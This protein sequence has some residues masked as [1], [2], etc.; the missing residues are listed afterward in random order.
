MR[1]ATDRGVLRIERVPQTMESIR[2]LAKVKKLATNKTVLAGH[3]GL[4][5]SNPKMDA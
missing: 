2:L 3:V 5:P 4:A 1:G